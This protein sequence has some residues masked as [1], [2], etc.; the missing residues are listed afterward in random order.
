L[1]KKKREDLYHNTLGFS[2]AKKKKGEEP[3][4]LERV[5]GKEVF[6]RWK[7]CPGGLRKTTKKTGSGGKAAPR[8]L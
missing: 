7:F 4:H 2:R 6:S 5:L 1:K 3:G 8:K